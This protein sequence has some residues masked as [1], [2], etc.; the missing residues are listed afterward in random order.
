MSALPTATEDRDDATLVREMQ[1]GNYSGFEQ[2]LDRHVHH[3]RAFLALKAPVEHLV[4]ELTHETFV[5]AFRHIGEFTTGTS[6][7]A[8]L[9]AIAWNLLRAEIQRFSRDQANQ[10]RFAAHW[11]CQLAQ[12]TADPC[13]PE[14]IEFLEHCLEQVPPRMRELLA[15]KYRDAHSS[16]EIARRLNQSVAWV[17]TMLFRVRQQLK[18][19]IERSIERGRPC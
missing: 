14:E 2:L 3:I 1:Q 11:I 15:M 7:Q 9:R 16:R 13:A 12:A 8:W 6:F 18:E 4:D 10:A 5:F 19:C 17:Y